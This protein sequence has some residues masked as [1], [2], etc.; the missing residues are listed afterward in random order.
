[1]DMP[2]G[3]PFQATCVLSLSP[4]LPCTKQQASFS[5]CNARMTL[6]MTW[7][8]SHWLVWSDSHLPFRTYAFPSFRFSMETLGIR[9]HLMS[10]PDT[11][12]ILFSLH[13]QQHHR[14]EFDAIQN[15]IDNVRIGHNIIAT[16]YARHL[17][18]H[19]Q[20]H[21]H[22]HVHVQHRPP[23]PKAIKSRG[24]PTYSHTST[25]RTSARARSR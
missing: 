14:L 11:D 2:P 24:R 5:S 18:V 16:P 7:T 8:R 6:T 17:H 9:H 4:S 20:A 21:V 15:Q 12:S 13:Q 23:M 3:S 25:S 22:V 1:M 19:V 10:L